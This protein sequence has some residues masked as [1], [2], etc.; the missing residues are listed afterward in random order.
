MQRAD[1]LIFSTSTLARRW[2]ELFPE[3]QRPIEVLANLAPHDLLAAATPPPEQPDPLTPLRLVFAS[4]T[5]A[6]KQ[7]WQE[8]LA[9]AIAVLLERNRSLR[10]DLLGHVQ[11][12]MQLLPFNDRIRCRPYASYA[13]YLRQLSRAQIGLVVLEPGTYTDAK[14]AIRWMEF[15]LLGLASVLSP[16]ATY[17]ELLSPGND[18]LFARGVDDWVRTVQRLIDDPDLRLRLARAAYA[19]ALQRFQPAQAD[20]F[21]QPLITD[22]S[23][24]LQRRRRLLVI[25]VF[26]A[27][28]SI[29][30][31]TRVAQDQVLQLLQRA[32]DRYEVT[33]L[34]ADHGPWQHAESEQPK[35]AVDSH[36]WNGARVV[37]LALPPRPWR[38]SHDPDVVTFCRRWFA[39]EGFDLIHA[40]C[41]QMLTAAPLQVAAE[42]GIPYLVTLHDGWW[43][44][45][46]LFLTTVSG[47]PIDPADPLGHYDDPSLQDPADLEGDRQRRQQL[48]AVLAGAVARLAVSEAFAAVYR[49]GGVQDVTV[50]ENDW[51]PMAGMLPRRG[52]P[53]RQS[54]LRLCFVGGL[55]LHKGYAVLQSAL[56][57]YNLAAAGEGAC[58]TVIDATLQTD[59]SYSLEWNGTPVHCRASVPMAAMAE[60]YAE[61]DVLIAP[62][63]WPESYGLVTREAL[64]AGLWVVASDIG[65][66][67]D[68]IEHGV[69]GHVV[70]PGDPDALGQVLVQL[71]CQPVISTQ[72]LKFKH[73]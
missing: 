6:H 33:V 57:R 24:A 18:V 42:L 38:D 25:N 47:R 26:F 34:C 68:P 32:G 51:Q 9:P 71:C 15:S 60:F 20:A 17:A 40:H 14:S 43:L 50:V 54:P 16:T 7:A 73:D 72:L 19:K 39:D 63:I 28:Q 23:P 69:N 10:L 49:A 27:P 37:R 58:L 21:W 29:G 12:P 41:L 36:G 59:Q 46:R 53:S 31:A 11:L 1:G 52:R 64:S 5:T 8:E 13:S 44:S 70:P 65:A 22:S 56:L 62:S 61:H 30:G 67:A 35:L 55:A 66:L 45:P 4:G 3:D 48:Q 2:R